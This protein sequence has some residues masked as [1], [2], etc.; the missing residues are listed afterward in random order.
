MSTRSNIIV[1]VRKEDIGKYVMFSKKRLGVELSDWDIYGDT[2][3]KEKAVPV[4]LRKNYIGVYCHCDGYPDGL[5]KVLLEK[6]NSY[7][8]VLNLVAGGSCSS[9]WFDMVRRYANR[10]GEAWK[11]IQPPT[12]SNLSVCCG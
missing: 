1:K 6:F 5:G 9:V 11:H 3:E 8:S 2:S 12:T 10:K 7:D 4:K